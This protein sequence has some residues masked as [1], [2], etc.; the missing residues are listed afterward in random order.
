MRKRERN[1][2]EDRDREGMLDRET[3]REE[4]PIDER[5]QRQWETETGDRK[6]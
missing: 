4:I 6:R 2:E 1:G 3:K 5:R